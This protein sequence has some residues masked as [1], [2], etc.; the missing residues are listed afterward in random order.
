[1]I[2]A[3]FGTVWA[4][5]ASAADAPAP[6]SV[7]NQLLVQADGLYERWTVE[8]SWGTGLMV[9]VL[10]EVSTRM[11]LEY[12]SAEPLVIGDI[13][14]RGGGQ[15]D[16]HMTHRMG[17]DADIGIYFRGGRQS[18]GGFVNVD[19]DELDCDATFG[20]I[21][22]LLDTGTVE[23][24]LLDQVLI[25]RLRSYALADLGL[26]PELVAS[27]FP[28]EGTA[29]WRMWGYVRHADNH[30]NHLHIHVGDPQVRKG[31]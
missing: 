15:I 29:T 20:L 24:I 3:I 16:G 19:P 4:S 14:R 2:A 21:R 8:R 5:G 11:A 12:P 6:P 26:D 31:S 17:E 22:A 30:R 9:D 1:L 10:T 23:Y 28:A 7:P 27:M 13:S 18:H 25:D